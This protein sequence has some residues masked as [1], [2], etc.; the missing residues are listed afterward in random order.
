MK[1]LLK[2]PF[3]V[4]PKTGRICVPIDMQECDDFNP[5]TVPTIQGLLDELSHSTSE[6]QHNRKTYGR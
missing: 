1:H 6:E 4:H 3:C 2:S 5:M